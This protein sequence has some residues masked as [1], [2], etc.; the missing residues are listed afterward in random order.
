MTGSWP[1]PSPLLSLFLLLLLKQY[2]PRSRPH[3]PTAPQLWTPEHVGL[4]LLL[5]LLLLGRRGRAPLQPPCG[6]LFY[7]P[8]AKFIR[9]AVVGGATIPPGH[10]V[11]LYR[12]VV[13][14]H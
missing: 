3:I 2:I 5:L 9:H 4:L 10:G 12:N 13:Y 7:V 14:I 1:P 8:L 6:H 11:I